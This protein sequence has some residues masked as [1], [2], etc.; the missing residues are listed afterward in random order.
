MRAEEREID[1]KEGRGK[2]KEKREGGRGQ[3]REG[4]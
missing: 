3:R 1:K 2:K 4:R